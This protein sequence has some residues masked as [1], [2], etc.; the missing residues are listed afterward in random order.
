MYYYKLA[1]FLSKY[2]GPQ[3]KKDCEDS[4]SESVAMKSVYWNILKV[5]PISLISHKEIKTDK[6]NKVWIK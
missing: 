1:P 5:F 2:A 3:T 4:E 6:L